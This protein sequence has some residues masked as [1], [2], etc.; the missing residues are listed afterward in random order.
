MSL[1]GSDCPVEMCSPM[2]GCLSCAAEPWAANRRR[3]E[4]HTTED[5]PMSRLQGAVKFGN[6]KVIMPLSEPYLIT[7]HL[8][9]PPSFQSCQPGLVLH[10]QSDPGAIATSACYIRLM[11]G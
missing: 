9:A 2:K 11:W 7:M 1:Q 8:L 10:C 6:K 5:A 4:R 3:I